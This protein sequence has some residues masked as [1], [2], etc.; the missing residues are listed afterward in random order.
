[1]KQT[2]ITKLSGLQVLQNS[3][4]VSPGYLERADNVTIVQDYI[5]T[6]ARGMHSAYQLP[7]NQ[8]INQ[9]FNYG[10]SVFAVTQNRLVRIHES[11]VT[12]QAASSSGLP[13]ITI[14][15]TAHGLTTGDFISGFQVAN[16]DAFVAAFPKRQAAFY[17]IREVTVIDPNTFTF[18]ATQNATASVISGATAASYFRYTRQTGEAISVTAGGVVTS[19][20]VKSNKNAYLTS[21]NGIMKLER[22]DLPLLKAGIPMGLDVQVVLDNATTGAITGPIGANKQVAYKV[23]FGRRD[24]NSNLV[25]G[26]PSE[27]ALARNT[28]IDIPT[29]S[30]S[31][32]DPTN[33]L[34]ITDTGHGLTSGDVIFI[35]NFVGTGGTITDG[36]PIPVT[37]IDPDT[38]SIDFDDIGITSI[39][40]VTSLS[41]GTRKTAYL[42]FSI[43]S[44]INSTDYLYQIYRTTESIDANTLPEEN[45]RLVYE[46]NLT[47]AFIS[48]GF[49]TFVDEVDQ[50]LVQ[51]GSQ[52][53]TNPTVEGPLQENA[54]PPRAIDVALFGGY[55]FYANTTDYRSLDL[56]LVAPS[57]ISNGDYVTLAT[58]QYI[59]RGNADNEPVG[60]E[61]TTSPATTS[62]TYVE[63]TQTNHGFASSDVIR[64][65]D[66]T[67]I[68]GLSPGTFTISAV[69]TA[70]TFRF[71]STASGSGTVTYEGL[72]DSTG[73]RLVKRYIANA[74][75]TLSE[76]IDLTT[77]L[78]VKAVNRDS[79]SPL[80]A[81]NVSAP[82][83]TP[84]KMNF[85]AKNINAS[86]F[87]A[88]ISNAGA[89]DAFVPSLP[90]SGTTV[91]DTQTV[92]PNALRIAKLN[93]PE[94]VPRTNELLV[95]SESAAIKRII[96][97]RTALIIWKDDGVYRLNGDNP[98]NFAVTALDT[99]VILKA[100]NSVAVLNNSSYGLTN[101]GVVQVT[102]SSVRISSREIEPFF[103]SIIG[104]SNV[105]AATSAIS[106]E[107]ER[108]YMLSTIT[109]GRNSTLPDVTYVYN[110]LTNA[111]TTY[112][113]DKRIFA[114]GLVSS[115]DDKLIS[116]QSS[117]KSLINRERK[118]QTKVDF[119]DQETCVPILLSIIASASVLNGGSLI[120]VST[121]NPHGLKAG[122]LLSISNA[123]ASMISAFSGG[124]S[125]IEGLRN[126]STIESDYEFT[127]VADSGSLNAASG[128]VNYQLNISEQT[129]TTQV[130]NGGT[131]A[132]FTTSLPHNL[133]SGTAITVNSISSALTAALSAATDLTGYRTVSV[134]SPTSFTVALSAAATGNATSTSVISDRK[135][136]RMFVTAITEN[137]YS[138]QI[139]D[140]IVSGNSIFIIDDVQRFSNTAYI[141][142]VR[143]KYKRQSTDLAFI[144][145]SYKSSIRFAPLTFGDASMMK[146]FSEFQATFRNNSSCT[147]LNVN[148]STDAFVSSD[149]NAWS[150]ATG[151][152]KT[153][154]LFGGWGSLPW[155]R[156]PWGG[157]TSIQREF[158]TRPAVLLRMYVPK[159]AYMGTFL[160]PILEHRV[161]GEPFELQSI[162]VYQQSVTQR[163]TR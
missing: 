144:N 121:L 66:S 1:M 64:V 125:D 5:V 78:F 71:A 150:F 111:W 74:D 103:S 163:T 24:A 94:A 145:S 76:S 79:L 23:V 97:L 4:T 62:G 155:G 115:L 37:V 140:A 129:V 80:Y 29:G 112:S 47:S 95:G 52:L 33:V 137:N 81:R 53:Y 39:T 119:T 34:T 26:E 116:V 90:T 42:T 104:N 98:N 70:N 134:L 46:A 15:K 110:Y 41:Y 60:N 162:S 149:A 124:A 152:S 67:G 114:T 86:T 82:N 11:V 57:L 25:L 18:L 22:E 35:F 20:I 123:S 49:G 72:A 113:G 109:P 135:Q 21:D 51:S 7:S 92:R 143:F 40:A 68:T 31:Y 88:T 160:Q 127:F 139:G 126:V 153:P 100:T 75:V 16:T 28:I 83:G 30:L 87:A 131:L 148:F 106:Y 142:H 89:S 93:E 48:Q 151:T 8:I 161:A 108:T 96:P 36:T 141:L 50:I 63:I 61:Q 107:S 156:F 158:T 56:A 138:P 136:Q 73:K 147:K 85:Q 102:D 159:Q 3:L 54:R 154:F 128:S 14:T 55:V 17:G 9:L 65:D 32:D 99:T 118:D 130:S 13:T 43:P 69:P 117:S 84:G 59:F 58:R 19:R 146:F 101:Q 6:K 133:T 122:D 10:T 45:Y 120:R 157:G 77:R 27:A 105:E 91:S 132:T 44:E 38:F 2:T 12:A